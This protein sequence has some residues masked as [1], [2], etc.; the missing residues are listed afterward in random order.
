MVTSAQ[1][2]IRCVDLIFSSELDALRFS[3]SASQFAGIPAASPFKSGGHLTLK[4][5][6]DEFEKIAAQRPGPWHPGS[7]I[8][9][10][11]RE[12]AA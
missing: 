3:V 10:R 6:R 1:Y 2:G 4:F 9:D 12:P 7:G 8:P 11:L 5:T